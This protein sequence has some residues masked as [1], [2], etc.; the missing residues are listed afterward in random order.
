MAVQSIR[1]LPK[2]TCITGPKK[3]FVIGGEIFRSMLSFFV[4]DGTYYGFGSTT[5]P[6]R[7]GVGPY[8]AL[9]WLWDKQ[10]SHETNVVGFRLTRD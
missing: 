8:L 2:A 9:R 5:F 10:K 1:S 4:V 3:C 6:G 7:L